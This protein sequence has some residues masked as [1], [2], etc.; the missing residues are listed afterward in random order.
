[1]IGEEDYSIYREGGGMVLHTYVQ[2]TKSRWL[3]GWKSSKLSN[4][5]EVYR[6]NIGRVKSEK[7]QPK[8]S[9]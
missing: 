4:V 7:I 6:R 1:M 5:N 9:R 3:N 2:C 8:R